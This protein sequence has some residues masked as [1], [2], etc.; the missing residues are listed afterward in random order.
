MI[1]EPYKVSAGPWLRWR[2]RFLGGI[3]DLKQFTA[4]CPLLHPTISLLLHKTH[5]APEFQADA[6]CAPE[7]KGSQN[8]K[9]KPT[10]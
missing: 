9:A 6:Q 3:T 7:P 8:V 10:F 5:K 2:A 1:L 4:K